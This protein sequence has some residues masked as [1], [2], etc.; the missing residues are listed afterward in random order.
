MRSIPVYKVS[1]YVS[2][3]RLAVLFSRSSSRAE[4]AKFGPGPLAFAEPSVP[5]TIYRDF[6]RYCL[7]KVDLQVK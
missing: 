7:P 3:G 1:L 5:R 4:D 6:S 2:K